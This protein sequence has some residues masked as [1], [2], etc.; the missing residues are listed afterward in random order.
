MNL[1]HNHSP[2]FWLALV[3]TLLFAVVILLSV[4]G[5]F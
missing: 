3:L 1:R 2:W 4:A 5:P